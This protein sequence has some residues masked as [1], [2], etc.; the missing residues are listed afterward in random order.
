MVEITNIEPVGG[1]PEA[2]LWTSRKISLS[3]GVLYLLTFVSIPTLALY[4]PVK[5]AEYMLGASQSIGGTIGGL[6]EIIVA[7]TCIGTAVV[8]YPLLKKQ[9]QVY[10]LGLVASRIL[11]AGTIFLGVAFILAIISLR[12][13][14]AGAESLSIS[15]MLAVLYDRIFLLG[16]S[17]LPA[18]NDLLLGV[19]LYQSRLVPR[20]LS[21]IGIIG[22]PILVVGYLATLF[23]VVD[24]HAASTGLFAVPV[25]L[26]ELLL[27]IWLIIKGFN[28]SA[29][30][31][32][33]ARK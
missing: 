8:L 11:E 10:A 23:G 31:S 5:S 29:F 15:H 17:F 2:S 12:E 20:L 9:N 6:L 14:G 22:A 1:V 16:Q 4:G 18:V 7:L 19:L 26:F 3:A 28:P 32:L 24:Q 27:G 21:S 30:A 25:A 33:D 13:S